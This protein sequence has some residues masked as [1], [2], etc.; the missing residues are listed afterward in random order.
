M[1]NQICYVIQYDGLS[2]GEH[3][4]DLAELGESLQGFSK[5]LACA[6]NYVATGQVSRQYG[7]LAVKVSTNAKLEAGC[8]EIPVWVTSHADSLF[9]GFAGAV[10]SAVMAFVLSRRGKKEMELLSKALEK[11]LDQNQELQTQNKELQARLLNTIEKLA[12]GLTA[13]NRQALAPIGRS[14]KTISVMDEGNTSSF[15]VA[16]ESLKRALN[17]QPEAK[18]LPIKE[19]AGTI[20]ELDLLSGSCKVSLSGDDDDRVN[21]VIADPE[22]EI[23]GNAYVTAFAKREELAF[24]AKATLSLDGEIVRLVISDTV[25]KGGEEMGNEVTTIAD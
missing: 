20:T 8:I 2:L 5:I 21:A 24:M 19:Y 4:I 22:L 18:V 6:G 7:K 14:C 12:D 25:K 11:A 23:P 15:V 16:D 10:L 9:S 13:A 17:S 3:E 1:E